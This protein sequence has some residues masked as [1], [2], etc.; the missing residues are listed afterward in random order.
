MSAD[1]PPPSPFV[2]PHAM[3]PRRRMRALV[4]ASHEAQGRFASPLAR[5]GIPR[6]D[7]SLLSLVNR[8]IRYGFPHAVIVDYATADP[9]GIARLNAE[10]PSL[11]ALL[12]GEC[13]N[14]S[15]ATSAR[16][17][18]SL[19]REVDPRALIAS[20]YAL[21][22]G[23]LEADITPQAFDDR[24]AVVPACG[25]IFCNDALLPLH[26]AERITLLAML[27]EPDRIFT[28]DEIAARTG[29]TMTAAYVMVARLRA[30]L[31]LHNP[32]RDY[33]VTVHGKGP[34]LAM[35]R[36]WQPPTDA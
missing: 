34:T 25:L 16:P 13:P 29:T 32:D 4:L 21:L 28:W 20:L 6:L 22:H 27:R 2:V 10:A 9:A 19:P 14:L 7:G 12:V 5:A 3:L 30:T 36:G 26:L 11:P 33:V 15:V 24:L 8:A 17:F 18:L 23:S 1:T 35:G 31:K